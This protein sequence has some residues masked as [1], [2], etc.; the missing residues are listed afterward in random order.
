MIFLKFGYGVI[1]ST[2]RIE[3]YN[4]QYSRL[5]QKSSKDMTVL[6][7]MFWFVTSCSLIGVYQRFGG[8]TCLHL[9]TWILKWKQHASP[10]RPPRRLQYHNPENHNLKNH[11]ENLETD[12]RLKFCFLYVSYRW[13]N[14]EY[15]VTLSRIWWRCVTC[16]RVLDWMVGFIDALYTPLGT[17]GNY[18]VIVDFNISHFPVTP[19]SVFGLQLAVSLQRIYD[20]HTITSNHTWSLPCPA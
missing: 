1:F 13:P 9:H 10:K 12:V 2:V 18:S 8:A 5:Y 16:R 19:T 7:V 20:S 6:I 14:R 15:S 3:D 4:I 11:H 17:T